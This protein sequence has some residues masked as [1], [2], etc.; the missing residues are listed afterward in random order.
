MVKTYAPLSIDVGGIDVR[1]IK[2]GT[3]PT[4][5]IVGASANN[6]SLLI[7][8]GNNYGNNRNYVYVVNMSTRNNI[9]LDVSTILLGHPIFG[10]VINGNIVEWWIKLSSWSSPISFFPL[11]NVGFTLSLESRSAEPSEIIYF[12]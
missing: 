12:T 11:L 3:S 7:A 6:L 4:P 1:F 8:G 10:Y 9:A 5:A 2:I